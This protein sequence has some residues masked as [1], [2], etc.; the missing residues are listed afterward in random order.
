MKSTKKL[1]LH[2]MS[3]WMSPYLLVW[4]Q[5]DMRDIDKCKLVHLSHM[6]T[7]AEHLSLFSHPYFCLFSPLLR[8]S[9]PL[10]EHPFIL[11]SVISWNISNRQEQQGLFLP[12]LLLPLSLAQLYKHTA[13]KQMILLF[14]EDLEWRVCVLEEDKT[15]IELQRELLQRKRMPSPLFTCFFLCPCLHLA[16]F[17][18]CSP[19]WLVIDKKTKGQRVNRQLCLYLIEALL[20]WALLQKL[21][22]YSWGGP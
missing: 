1:A 18:S 2:R 11:D 9:F 6:W 12:L 22:S 19:A 8:L 7:T 20:L 5:S 10:I 4:W 16:C 14:G 21:T 13:L 3:W 17:Y 15:G